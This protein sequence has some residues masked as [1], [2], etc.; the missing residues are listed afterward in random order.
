MRIGTRITA[1][2][3]AA[4][5]VPAAA[6]DRDA[7]PP[8]LVTAVTQCRAITED[9]ARLRCF[10]AAA[11]AL[12]SAVERQAVVIVD[13]EEIEARRREQFGARRQDLGLP[14]IPQDEESEI[15][16]VDGVIRSAQLLRDNNWSITL[17]DGTVWRQTDGMPFARE[18]RAGDKV[19]VREAALGT[20]KMKIGR[21]PAIRVR[22][23]A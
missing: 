17:E 22:R 9:A 6:R 11:A 10:D 20:F 19:N 3:A 21:Q 4:L 8:K 5:A 2:L 1:A 15:H 13:K 12:G 7:T 18:P 14:G 23:V 16:E